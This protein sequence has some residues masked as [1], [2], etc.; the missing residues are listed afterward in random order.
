M[1]AQSLIVV[2]EL[3]PAR[4]ANFL[5]PIVLPILERRQFRVVESA[6]RTGEAECHKTIFGH[7]P[8]V[9]NGS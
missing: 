6:N 8:N 4:G 3:G 1:M 9:R 2:A 5:V 7:P